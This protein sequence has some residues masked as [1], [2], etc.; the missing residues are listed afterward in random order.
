M[1]SNHS[2]SILCLLALTGPALASPPPARAAEGESRPRSIV[3]VGTGRQRTAPDTAELTFTI[4]HMAPTADAAGQGAAKAAQRV[5]EVLRKEAGEGARVETAGFSLSPVYQQQDPRAARPE[6]P[7]KIVGYSASHDIWV[8]SPRVDGVGTIVDAAVAA[9][10]DRI[11]SL[12]FTVAD[13]DPVRDR[14]LAAAGADAARQARVVAD[15]LG[16]ELT[17]VRH[18]SVESYARPMLARSAGFAMAAEARVETPI[19]PGEVTTE[20]RLQ[21]T[22]GIK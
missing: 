1:R 20:M 10:A 11:R 14:A 17:E 2:V 12:S 7:P 3:V 9:G 8:R 13:S 19:Q 18:A 5:I 21:V 6:G 4:E 22:Y 15:A 16:V